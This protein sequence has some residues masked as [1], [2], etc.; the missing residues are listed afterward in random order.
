MQ[1]KNWKITKELNGLTYVRDAN[2]GLIY[3][4]CISKAKAEIWIAGR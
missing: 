2:T 3:Q 4:V 1:K